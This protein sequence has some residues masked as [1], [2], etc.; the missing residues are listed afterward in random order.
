MAGHGWQGAKEGQKK[1]REGNIYVQNN[2]IPPYGLSGKAPPSTARLWGGGDLSLP[3]NHYCPCHTCPTCSARHYMASMHA[4]R[5]L[6]PRHIL[7]PL[8][9]VPYH[10]M[11]YTRAHVRL[12]ATAIP[13]RC[14][15]GILL[16]AKFKVFLRFV[17]YVKQKRNTD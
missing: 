7:V 1:Y 12:Y 17:R 16:A 11:P 10:T 3:P 14:N 9:Y 4:T 2:A 15:M 8:P 5:A 13:S 6:L